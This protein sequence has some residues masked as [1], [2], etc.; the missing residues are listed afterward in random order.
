VAALLWHFTARFVII[1]LLKELRERR[2]VWMDKGKGRAI[3]LAVLAAACYG[4]SSPVSKLL[5]VEI[6]P[7]FM[8]ALLYL[9]AGIGMALL[10][11]LRRRGKESRE[12]QI[13]RKEAPLVLAVIALDI[14]A[15]ILLMTGLQMT[16]PANVSLLNNFEIVATSMLAMLFFREAVGGRMWIVIAL[17]TLASVLLSVEDIGHFSFSLGSLL[18]ILASLCWGLENN[19]TRL[20]SLKDPLQIV[21]VKGFGSGLGALTIALIAGAVRLDLLYIFF[22]LLLGFFAYGLSIFLYISAQRSLGAARTS[23]YYAAAP[24]IGVGLSLVIYRQTVTFTF[25]IALAL[26]VAAAFFAMIEK[27]THP[28]AHPAL[29]HEHRHRHD[30][31]HHLHPHDGPALE[32]SHP[33]THEEMSHAHPHTPDLHHGHGH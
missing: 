5:L 10:S 14:L 22:A 16:N 3:L 19:C 1:L 24:F 8:A 21:V 13:T 6:P 31:G 25:A 11:L 33:H 26:M 9:G 27:H 32:H 23:A 2:R 4:I 7:A 15:P 20:L 18:V 17:I 28:H 29:S 30:D 12:A